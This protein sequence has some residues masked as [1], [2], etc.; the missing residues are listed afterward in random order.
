MKTLLQIFL[1]TKE[2]LCR[3][4]YYIHTQKR[5]LHLTNSETKI[6]HLMGMQYL[7]KPGQFTGDYGV[8]MIKKQRIT[9]ES[10]EKLVRKYYKPEEKQRRMLEMIHRKLDNIGELGE[11]FSLYSKLYLYEKEQNK[12]SEFQ[13]DYLLV[14]ENRKKILHLGLVK[15]ESGKG[16]YHCNSFMTTYENDRD[17]D[18]FFRDLPH[19]YE[20]RKIVRENKATEHKEVIYQSME[21][22]MREKSGIEKMLATADIQADQKLIRLILQLNQKFDIYHT[23]DMLKDHKA[24]YGKCSDQREIK[25]VDDF[26]VMWD[27]HK[28][29]IQKPT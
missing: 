27:E 28:E 14:H 2:V 5:I 10:V 12:D 9:M 17:R 19:R 26:F 7:G 21:A 4:D 3:Y 20:I 25:L 1:D 16:I 22:Q 23:V 8:Y 11:M 6:P 18:F 24:M 29:D 15:S 13:S